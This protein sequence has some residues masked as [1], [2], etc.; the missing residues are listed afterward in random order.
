MSTTLIMPCPNRML[1]QEA[2]GENL[3]SEGT[4]ASVQISIYFPTVNPPLGRIFTSTSC[5]GVCT[6]T[7]SQ[8]DADLCAARQAMDCI[9][10]NPHNP[11]DKPPVNPPPVNP[12]CVDPVCVT[13]GGCAFEPPCC[14]P[15]C[16]S[17]PPC[18]PGAA[19]CPFTSS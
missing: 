14:S 10:G 6:S 15:P 1:C 16:G 13:V 18:V 17:P 4:D 9:T 11:P 7:I 5:I 2:P 3:T 8:E 12:P 19:A